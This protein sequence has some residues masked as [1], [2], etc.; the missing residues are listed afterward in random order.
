MQ[1]VSW[2][3]IFNIFFPLWGRNNKKHFE[4]EWLGNLEIDISFIAILRSWNSNF[5]GKFCLWFKSSPRWIF[6]GFC[7]VTYK[8]IIKTWPKFQFDMNFGSLWLLTWQWQFLNKTILKIIN[9][10]FLNGTVIS[11]VASSDYVLLALKW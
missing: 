6:A 2:D 1:L 4:L 8:T 3:R 9:E 5:L 11:C 7:E 10:A